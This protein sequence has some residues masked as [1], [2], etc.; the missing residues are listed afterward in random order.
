[1]SLEPPITQTN[2]HDP[3]EF[4]SVFMDELRQP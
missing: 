3:A 1:M 2:L 4:A